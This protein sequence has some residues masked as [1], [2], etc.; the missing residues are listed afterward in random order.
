MGNTVILV[1]AVAL[2]TGL[3][4]LL[5]GYFWGRSNV[6]SQIEDALDQSRRIA[7]A[8]E[9]NLREALEEKMLELSKLRESAEE[10]PRLREKLEQLKS[11]RMRGSA[12]GRA[13]AFESANNSPVE[14]TLPATVR[15]PAPVPES[16]DKAIQNLLKSIEERMNGDEEDSQEAIEESAAPAVTNFAVEIPPTVTQ[17]NGKPAPP[18]A[19]IPAAR[20]APSAK[21][22]PAPAAKAQPA[23]AAK[24]QP[25]QAAKDEWQEFAASLAALKNRQK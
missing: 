6:R 22:Q 5:G 17:L 15:A 19:A 14:P 20:P 21:A 16:A 13:S 7:D 2:G 12:S 8:R 9:Y 3:I 24:A 25:A 4:C 1:G 18:P 10:L 11:E 23:P